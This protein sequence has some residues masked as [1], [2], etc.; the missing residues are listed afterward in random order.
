MLFGLGGR[1][2]ERSMADSLRRNRHEPGDRGG[3]FVPRMVVVRCFRCGEY[4]A[5][6]PTNESHKCK[7][8]GD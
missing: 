1:I 3:D 4:Y 5:W 7:D 6:S 8:K 2:L